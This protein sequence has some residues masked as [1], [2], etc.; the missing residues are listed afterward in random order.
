MLVVRREPHQKP[1]S[2]PAT[3]F[4]EWLTLL[5]KLDQAE[6]G[7]LRLVRRQRQP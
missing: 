2:I 1:G 3:R 6:A 5:R 4:D 7:N